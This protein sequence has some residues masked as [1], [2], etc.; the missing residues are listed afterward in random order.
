MTLAFAWLQEGELE[1]ALLWTEAAWE[2]LRRPQPRG[3]RTLLGDNN[4]PEPPPISELTATLEALHCAIFQQMPAPVLR[5][6]YVDRWPMR[7]SKCKL[8]RVLKGASARARA[9]EIVAMEHMDGQAQF[10]N[11]GFAAD[12]SAA[13]AE[14]S[15]AVRFRNAAYH[16]SNAIV[17]QPSDGRLWAGLARATMNNVMATKSELPHDDLRLVMRHIE[18]ASNHRLLRGTARSHA[19]QPTKK[20]PEAV[21]CTAGVSADRAVICCARECGICTGAGCDSRPGGGQSCCGGSITKPCWSFEG[22]P[23]CRYTGIWVEKFEMCRNGTLSDVG[24]FCCPRECVTCGGPECDQVPL[25]ASRCCLG[26]T[27]R[28]C[29]SAAGPPPCRY[30]SSYLHSRERFKI[31]IKRNGKALHR[32]LFDA[33]QG[34]SPAPGIFTTVA[35]RSVRQRSME[36]GMP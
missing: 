11:I 29:R 8:R 6:D 28:I 26:S 10:A 32:A 18:M 12:F 35:K 17:L 3:V 22:P 4:P 30:D 2:L 14:R 16:F 34:M 27:H 15:E 19:K 20:Q 24:H 36:R 33:L 1:P 9:Q 7:E 23:P 31:Q 5:Y 13:L 25:G 21:R